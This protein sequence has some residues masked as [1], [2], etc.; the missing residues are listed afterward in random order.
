MIMLF[1]SCMRNDSPRNAGDQ[2]VI[3]LKNITDGLATL[4]H[5]I[6]GHAHEGCKVYRH[7][8]SG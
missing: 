4:D 5:G 1:R 7:G 6:D 2:L 8:C 3:G